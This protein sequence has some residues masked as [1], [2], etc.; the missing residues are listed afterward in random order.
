MFLHVN[1]ATYISDYKLK[2]KFNNDE[3]KKV[4]LKDELYGEIFEPLKDKQFFKD[5]F[6]SHN[7][8]EWKNGADFAPEFLFEIGKKYNKYEETNVIFSFYKFDV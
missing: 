6:I 5:F 1:E 2:L 8:I 7:T 3:V 4:D